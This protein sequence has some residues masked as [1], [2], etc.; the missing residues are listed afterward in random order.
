MSGRS[1]VDFAHRAVTS[2]EYRLAGALALVLLLT[3]G[4]QVVSQQRAY[5]VSERGALLQQATSNA[6]NGEQLAKA[7]A[8]FRLQSRIALA[9]RAGATGDAADAALIDNAV[10]I[11]EVV[12]AIRL[13]GSTDETVRSLL[14]NFER[15]DRQ[16]AAVREAAG[17]AETRDALA[18]EIDR[19]NAELVDLAKQVEA[20]FDNQNDAALE[21][22]AGSIR[23]WQF[24][25]TLAG[26]GTALL[27]LLVLV[28]LLKTI[29]PALRRMHA[30]LRRLADG[31]LDGEVESFR[32]RELRDLSGALE[33]FRRNA[34]AVKNLAFTDASTG[35]PNRRAFIEGA[36]AELERAA[37]AGEN[38]A[39]IIAD[40]DRFKH[41]NDDCGH[42]AGDRLVRLAGER[43]AA[44]LNDHAIVAR[45]GGDEFAI[46]C[47]LRAGET[48]QALGS[49]LVE[50]MRP[51][52]DMGDFNLALTMSLGIVETSGQTEVTQLM[53]CADIAL[54]ASKNAGRNRASC[55]TAEL[56]ED[57]QLDRLLERDM[58]DGIERGEFRMVYQPIHPV[59]SSEPEVEAL[60]RWCHPELG[61]IS[62]ARFIPAAERSGQMVQLGNWIVEAAL[63]DLTRWE[64]LA[65]SVNLSPI[66]LQQEGFAG[67]L[68]DCCRRNSIL[69][70]RLCLEVTETL[71]IERNPRA[72]LTLEVLR[73]AGF[74]IALDDFGTGY[75]SLCL[76]KTFQFD[77]LKLDRSLINDLGRDATSR[78]VFEAAVTM[79]LRIGAEVVA[80]GISEEDMIEPVRS[81]GCTHLQGYHYS[82]P[83]EAEQVAGYYGQRQVQRRDEVLQVNELRRNVA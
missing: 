75:S 82:R 42:S 50:A 72:L 57:R 77:R 71:S 79:A 38:H 69:P 81:A 24:F 6:E 41:V 39:I 54:Y 49:R 60:I 53:N 83:I 59:G 25:I 55:F 43:I 30:H 76:I 64:D 52:F 37:A 58:S 28:D 70:Q 40:I 20:R 26:I 18:T 80:E 4:L 1:L 78:A 11:G 22:V 2:L 48:A 16:V 31:D 63:R 15:I 7:V 32:L 9:G 66:Q 13:S 47:A 65:M 35:M 14:A 21:S 12:N 73:Q 36:E 67:F 5:D 34:L 29:L 44:M 56:E 10:E 8:Q 17:Q 3:V 45:I 33:T 27:T 51:P 46:C 19:R 74:R 23:D 62:P 61:E 68:L